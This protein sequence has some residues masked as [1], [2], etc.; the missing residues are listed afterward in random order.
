MLVRKEKTAPLHQLVT[1]SSD[2]HAHGLA[3]AG[4]LLGYSAHIV[5]PEPVNVSKRIRVEEFG[6]TVTVRGPRV[7]MRRHSLKI[8]CGGNATGSFLPITMP[9]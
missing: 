6:A 7:R 8:R 2:N 1:V 3:W 9:M 5:I 4:Q